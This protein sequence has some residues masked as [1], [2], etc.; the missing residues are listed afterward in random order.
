MI[1]VKQVKDMMSRKPTPA[2]SRH[3]LAWPYEGKDTILWTQLWSRPSLPVHIRR[4][5]A[6]PL[7]KVRRRRGSM[8]KLK[9]SHS[10]LSKTI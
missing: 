3:L 8:P 4:P 5:L 1:P 2:I 7:M 10:T 6:I 9:K